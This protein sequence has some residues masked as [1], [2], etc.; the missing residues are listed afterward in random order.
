LTTSYPPGRLLNRS[1]LSRADDTPS[2]S[3]AES[4]VYFP[5]RC[6]AHRTARDIAR[7][8]LPPMTCL[9]PRLRNRSFLSRFNTL[10]AAPLPESLVSSSRR[11]H[12][13]HAACRNACFLLVSTPCPPR[14]LPNHSFLSRFN[15]LP[16]VPLAESLI[17]CARRRPTPS[18]ARCIARFFLPPTI[19][20][21]C[22]LLNRS[23]LSLFDVLPAVPLCESLVYFSRRR[24]AHHATL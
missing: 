5:F 1:I 24:L 2:A 21:L 7:F 11:R 12:S 16:D 18:A 17:S 6:L 15:V 14:C 9:L 10:P 19:R 23:F 20:P 22:R 4:L 8:F 13:R 3:I